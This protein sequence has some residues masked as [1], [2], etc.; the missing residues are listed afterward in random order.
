MITVGELMSYDVVNRQG[1][2]LGEVD[3]I[4]RNGGRLFIVMAHGGFLGLGETEVAIPLAEAV[5]RDE[6]LILAGVTPEEIERLP[7]YSA[8]TEQALSEPSPAPRCG[9]ENRG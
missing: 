7:E 3:R 2:D 8:E 5:I 4:V 9:A 1:E 6:R